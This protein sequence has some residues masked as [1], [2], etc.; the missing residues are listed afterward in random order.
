LGPS[1][2]LQQLVD[3][4][5]NRWAANKVVQQAQRVGTAQV[6][7]ALVRVALL[8]A[9]LKGASTL[10]GRIGEDPGAGARIVLERGLLDLVV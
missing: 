2:A 7:A 9:E 5:A 10:Q 3:G 1:Q 8:D 6:D 4:G